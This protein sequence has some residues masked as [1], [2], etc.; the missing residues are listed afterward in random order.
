MK[1]KTALLIPA[2]LLCSLLSGCGREPYL[3]P[4]GD[5]LGIAKGAHVF[6]D[7]G[8][9]GPAKDV[10]SVTSVEPDGEGGKGVLV[11]FDLRD[12]YRESIRENI[13]GAVLR[14]PSVAQCAFVLLLGGTDA[15]KG[16]ILPG[17]PIQEAKPAA[18]AASGGSFLEWL[19]DA[20][21]G[22]LAVLA[23]LLVVLLVLLA[24]VRRIVKIVVVLAILGALAYA[25]LSLGNGWAE[26]KERL[27]SGAL[28]TF[29]QATEWVGQHAGELRDRL[30]DV[31][32]AV[33]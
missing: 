4:V 5:G 28:R 25:A 15:S 32:S 27:E 19:G 31:P 21:S 30:S 29:E 16:P 17:L 26:Q 24:F 3:L 33:R 13:A 9:A 23:A 20:R 2:L 7:E 6:W 11:R 10:G 22:E 12:E 8:G 18:S 14:D 1:A